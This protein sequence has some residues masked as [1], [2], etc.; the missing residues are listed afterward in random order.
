ML[1][2]LEQTAHSDDSDLQKQL[3]GQRQE[4]AE[5]KQQLQE[6]HRLIEGLT[7]QVDDIQKTAAQGE[8]DSF[9]NE[10]PAPATGF[11]L[12]N[13][14]IGGEAGVAFFDTKEVGKGTGLGLSLCYGIVKEHGGTIVPKSRPGE[15]AAFVITLPITH[16]TAPPSIQKK[17]APDTDVINPREGLGKRVVVVDDED[18]ILQMVREALTRRGYQVDTAADGESGLNHIN[19]SN[20]D[21]MLFD[22]KMPGLNGQEVH[23]QLRQKDS[24]L[25]ERVI[26]I[27]GDVVNERVLDLV[28]KNKKVFFPK[29][30]S[31]AEFR[32]VIAKVLSAP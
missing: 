21:L 29:P 24:A 27:T 17:R 22:W 16:E 19:Q 7:Q 8:H 30:F 1:P 18:A 14:H 9:Q 10:M 28:E 13:V 25:A 15:G 31:M 2:S 11:D 5:L 12:S 6:Q 23:E 32:E 4:N 20:Y 26:F 3:E